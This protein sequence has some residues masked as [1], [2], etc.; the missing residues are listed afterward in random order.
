VA[1]RIFIADD[2][3]SIRRLLR[4]LIENHAGWSVC[5]DAANG[6]EAVGKAAQLNP[7]V[8]V[9]DLAMPEKNGLQA[10]REISGKLPDIPLLLLTVQQV[11]RELIREALHAGFMGVVSKNKGSEVVHAIET[12][13]KHQSFFEKISADAYA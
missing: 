6:Q 7:D 12:L 2:D 4:R 8:I 3:V 1:V 13:L 10:A 5:D 11:S 9:L